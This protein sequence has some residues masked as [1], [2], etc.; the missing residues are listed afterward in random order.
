MF[1]GGHSRGL[2]EY[3]GFGVNASS[4]LQMHYL[5]RG[6]FDIWRKMGVAFL[7]VFHV[8][9]LVG[10]SGVEGAVGGDIFA[11]CRIS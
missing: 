7:Y 11:T 5:G 4:L 1:T 9:I 2:C 10:L 3:V 6:C 8:G